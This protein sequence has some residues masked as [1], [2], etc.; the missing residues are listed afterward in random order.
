MG[1]PHS[2]QLFTGF[3]WRA[4][5]VLLLGAAIVVPASIYLSML[6]GGTL[7]GA[8]AF[9]IAVLAS[10]LA[11]TFGA[12]LTKQELLI[13]YEASSVIASANAAGIGF[14]WIIFRMFYVKNPITWAYTIDGVP[15]PLR[16]PSWL[17]PPLGSSAYLERTLFHPDILAPAL[18]YISFTALFLIAELAMLMI[19][20]FT[21]LE[22]E[23]LPFPFSRIDAMLVDTLS[24]RR[25]DRVKFF[26]A[27]LTFG[28]IYGLF[29][30]ALPYVAGIAF[31]PLPWLDLTPLTEP[32]MPGA[33][34]GI[35]TD[36]TPWAGGLVVPFEAG[37]GIV[38]GSMAT[39]GFGN[40]L[41]REYLPGVFPEWVSEYR[42]GMG[43]ALIW[44]RSMFRVWFAPQIGVALGLSLVM[45]AR[46]RRSIAKAFAALSR[47][48]KS[49]A[50][51]RGYPSMMI[52]ISMYL[53]GTT[54]SALLHWYLTGFPLWISL[55]YSVALS[56][57]IGVASTAAIGETGFSI[58]LP[59]LWHTI[60]Y[61]S[62]YRDYP[63]WVIMPVLA[64]TQSPG[65][66]NMMSAAYL[67]Q[68]KPMD[69]VKAI[70]VA[71]IVTQVLGVLSL[72]LF[73]R[74][75]PIPSSAYPFT[76]FDWARIAIGDSLLVTRSIRIDPLVL[77]TSAGAGAGVVALLEALRLYAGVPISGPGFVV[78][79]MTLTPYAA[80]VFLSSALSNLVLSKVFGRERW[81]EMRS[82]VAAGM[83]A[84]YG[85]IIGL[86]IAGLF[87]AKSSWLWPW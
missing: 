24:E 6:A 36:L 51:S 76:L 68:T 21:F 7:A 48:I 52:L 78:G 8:A 59:Y 18:V 23:R 50:E 69:L 77:L 28:A 37:V 17:A 65:L 87:I 60:V 56:L 80:S 84:G 58:S 1:E 63:G 27:A 49:P 25:P 42:P 39:W 64:G 47:A 57:L 53:A 22:V 11:I 30:V 70:V 15:I 10:Q 55:L 54:G 41:V 73:W 26:M 62:D 46:F 9:I 5:L 71:F 44:Q 75:A 16:V 82:V 4:L 19:L 32:Y 2:P 66:T 67:T 86:S 45:I 13:I 35:A 40:W 72:D 33:L 85:I 74:I 3:T 20:S 83:M 81:M 29:V 79:V 34:L 14:Y 31:I 38:L 12:P 61:F 43:I